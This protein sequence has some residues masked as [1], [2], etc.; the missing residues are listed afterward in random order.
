MTS[1]SGGIL[2]SW[3]WWLQAAFAAYLVALAFVV[4]LPPREAGT[5]TGFV[6]VVASWLSWLG[7]PY[8]HA[9]V[10]VE[11]V[12]N[13]VMFVPLG[14]LLRVLWPM[15]WNR[16]RVVVMGSGTSTA[17]ELTQLLIPGRVTAL[18]DVIANTVGALIGAGAAAWFGPRFG[19]SGRPEFSPGGSLDSSCGRTLAA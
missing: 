9:A 1:A 14:A 15:V 10:G 4:F 13:I 18:S 12:A 16:W 5:V 2:G 7:L 17:I 19:S 3:R 6:G 8:D 11:F